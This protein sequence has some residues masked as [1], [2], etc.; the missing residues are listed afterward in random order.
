MSNDRT[1]PHM[2]V[3]ACISVYL[4]RERISHAGCTRRDGII[5]FDDLKTPGRG[6]SLLTPADIASRFNDISRKKASMPFP[7]LV[8]LGFLG[9]AFI[10]FAAQGSTVVANDVTAY[11]VSRLTTGAV[12]TVGLMLVMLAGAELFTGNSLMSIGLFNGAISWQGLLRNWLTVYFSNFLGT[13]TVAYLIKSSGLWHL[14]ASKVGLAAVNIAVSKV[15]LTF[16]EALVRGILCNWIVC[17]AVWIAIGAQDATGKVLGIF[18]PVMLFVSSG[19]EHSIA[20]M[21]YI[22][23]GILAAADPKVAA[24]AGFPAAA[25]DPS[26]L[27]WGTLMTK[28]LLPVTLGNIIGGV[29]FVGLLYWGVYGAGAKGKAK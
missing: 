10:A 16:T 26:V 6:I 27:G 4:C 9:G 15:S 14:N 29:L 13:V 24:V 7:S 5:G 28:N 3:Q 18:F 19:F 2:I 23:A 1:F 21:Y 25:T 17:L 8:I 22:P 12:F 20:N 11:G